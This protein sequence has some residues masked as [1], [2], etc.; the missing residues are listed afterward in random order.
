MDSCD[1]FK[2]ATPGSIGK[3]GVAYS[4]RSQISN[5]RHGVRETVKLR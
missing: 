5:S 2:S 4:D 3:A 1:G